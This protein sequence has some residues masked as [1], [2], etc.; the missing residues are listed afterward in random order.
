MNY[1]ANP[2]GAMIAVAMLAVSGCSGGGSEVVSTLPQVDDSATLTLSGLVTDDPIVNADVSFMVGNREFPGGVPTGSRGEFQLQVVSDNP[3]DMVVGRAHD[4]A[5]GVYLTAVLDTFEGCINRAV[6]NVVD[7][8][9]VTN[10]TTA[11]Q[12]LAERLALDGS[13]D[14]Y[15]EYMELSEQIDAMEL[16]ELA[17]SI[18]SVVENINGTVLPSG[19]ENTLELARAIASGS[20]TFD[21]DVELL[22]PGTLAFA[23]D[24][25]LNDGHATVPFSGGDAPGVYASVGQNF[26]YAVFADG[27]A[28]VEQFDDTAIPGTPSWS[29]T[30]SG[31]LQVNFVNFRRSADR[32]TIMGNADNLMHVVADEIDGAGAAA[33]R[34]AATVKKYRFGPAF[35]A[36]GVP[37]TVA[38]PYFVQDDLVFASDGTG[39]AQNRANPANQ[40]SFA[41][42]I[43]AQGNLHLEFANSMRSVEFVNLVDSDATTVL[44]IT[45]YDNQYPALAVNTWGS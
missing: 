24:K 27:S 33:G 11:Q 2:I 5:N 20:S 22:N 34:D 31:S 8:V 4:A 41:W 39:V 23:R 26:V 18:K 28:M 44:S 14:G 38:D 21:S 9:K 10:I 30:D 19:Y 13:I 17:A 35:D 37:G 16:L 42:S 6:D 15:A 43:N 32:L 25:L 3:D 45:R 7:N 29:I 36:A 40:T 12:V 1:S